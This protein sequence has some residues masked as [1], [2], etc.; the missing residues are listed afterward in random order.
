M[1]RRWPIV[2]LAC[3]VTLMAVEWAGAQYVP[4]VHDSGQSV[5]PVYEGFYANPDGSVSVSFG[6][7]N[8]NAKEEVAI[9]L[10]PN[11]R[12]D[13]E[14][15]DRGQPTNFVTRRQTGVFAVTLPKG[16]E[17]KLTWTLSSRGETFSIPAN[18]DALYI[19][20]PLKDPTNGN[21]PPV[22]KF[23]AAGQSATGLVGLTTSLKT[24]LS[25]PLTLD[26][27]ATDDGV[28]QETRVNPLGSEALV[29]LTW[30]KYRGPGNVT[31]GT[32]KPSID[33]ANKATTTAKFSAP[34]EYV[35]RVLAQD[36]GDSG[37]QC[38]WTNGFVKVSVSP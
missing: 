21:T 20:T 11:N 19:L 25:S 31:F 32:A 16:A 18:F 24:S 29:N 7:L 1:R 10:G 35:L 2:F 27:W 17:Q 3:A 30:S 37:S 5:V 4:L 9:P 28:R 38:C 36:T 33:K 26:V 12:F 22:L 15:S 34:G 13:P 14:P 6:Y 8:R 23:D